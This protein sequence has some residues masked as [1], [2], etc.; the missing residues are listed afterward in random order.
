MT[1]PLK[2]SQELNLLVA[3]AV[4]QIELVAE[5]GSSDPASHAHVGPVDQHPRDDQGRNWD[6]SAGRNLG[7]FSGAV[8]K[9]VDPL[10]DRYDLAD[11]KALPDDR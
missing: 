5:G 9:V 4:R 3:D 6:V 8:T 1:K 11:A 2:T 7:P 10:R